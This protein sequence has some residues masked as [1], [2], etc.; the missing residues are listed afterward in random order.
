MD[1]DPMTRPVG[2]LAAEVMGLLRG[3]MRREWDGTG[4]VTVRASQ[5]PSSGLTKSSSET[6]PSRSAISSTL[7]RE[8]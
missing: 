3:T 8:R 6:R 4:W 2:A 7:N 1:N 5:A